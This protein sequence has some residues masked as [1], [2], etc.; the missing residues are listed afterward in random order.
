MGRPR[1]SVALD[2]LRL[3]ERANPAT[4]TI[5]APG[6][7]PVLTPHS[8]PS[9][10]FPEKLITATTTDA[11]SA[12]G[13]TYTASSVPATI[14][15]ATVTIPTMTPTTGTGVSTSGVFEVVGEGMV[16]VGDN[17]VTQTGTGIGRVTDNGVG[18]VVQLNGK[19][20][21]GDIGGDGVGGIGGV[22]GPTVERV[23]T[24]TRTES[25]SR[26]QLLTSPMITQHHNAVETGG[27]G[28]VGA[29]MGGI[30]G[31]GEPAVERIP[32]IRTGSLVGAGMGGIGDMVEPAVERIPV[33]R[34]G[35][36][37]GTGVDGLGVWLGLRWREYQ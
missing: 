37:V 12:M 20:N 23:Y 13:T 33:T 27:E 21:A 10:M 6:R 2:M 36:L 29:G 22:V 5:S 25:I 26:G 24:S 14:S 32:V 8:T 31:M 30:G 11:L 15:T 35:S 1:S 19:V 34:S 7:A 9:E 3:N 4:T 18:K 28:A 16:G 17:D